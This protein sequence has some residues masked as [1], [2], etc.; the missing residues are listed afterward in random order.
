MKAKQEILSYER[1]GQSVIYLHKEGIF[2]RA[3]EYSAYYFH[4]YIQPNYMLHKRFYRVVGQEVIYLGF[5][6]QVLDRLLIGHPFVG[7]RSS[8]DPSMVVL[9]LGCLPIT[10]ESL[11]AFKGGISYTTAPRPKSGVMMLREQ[12]SAILSPPGSVAEISYSELADRIRGFDLKGSTAM[13]A[14]VFIRGLKDLV[15]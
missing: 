2:Y 7:R 8:D 12:A 10:S 13:D 11:A 1:P 14:L 15:Q 4:T 6:E 3:Y 9:Y 5:P